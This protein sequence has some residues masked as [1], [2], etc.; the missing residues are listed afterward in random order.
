MIA[1][2]GLVSSVSLGE[3]GLWQAPGYMTAMHGL[4]ITCHERRIKEH[5]EA[6]SAQFTRC[7]NCHNTD[8]ESEM[9]HSGP[10]ATLSNAGR[11][12]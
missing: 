12:Q 9:R 10:Y 6:Y 8:Y 4:C 1:S 3:P 5:P 11:S 7:D 2:D